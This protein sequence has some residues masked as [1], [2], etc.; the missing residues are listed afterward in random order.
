VDEFLGALEHTTH[1]YAH[2]PPP[3]YCTTAA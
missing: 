2:R 3:P 1:M